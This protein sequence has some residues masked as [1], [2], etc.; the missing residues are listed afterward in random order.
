MREQDFGNFQGDSEE[1][2][3]IW[4]AR[5]RYGHFFFRIPNGESAADV[6]DRCAG[7]NESLFRQ[8]NQPHF[9]EVLVL[10]S[11][12]IWA[13]VFL[14]KWYGWSYEKFESLRNVRHCQF[15]QMDLCPVKKRYTL[16][17]R[18]RTWDDTDEEDVR[19]ASDGGEIEEL[20]IASNNNISLID[21]KK[22]AAK[23]KQIMEEYKSARQDSPGPSYHQ[24]DHE[25]TIDQH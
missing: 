16:M 3:R 10:V 2:Q 23:E 5:A 17:T 6:Y 21:I 24:N 4:T 19:E 1:M 15:L 20:E 13:R 7:F 25:K 9:P 18:L 8:F 14:M 22:I 12:G 11:H